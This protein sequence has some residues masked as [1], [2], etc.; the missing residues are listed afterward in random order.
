MINATR[1]PN[2]IHDPDGYI[3]NRGGKLLRV[4]SK[5]YYIN[6]LKLVGTGLH[7]RLLHN[8]LLLEHTSSPIIE[9]LT[10][11]PEVVP[12]ISYPYE[13]SFSQLR[14]AAL[15]TLTIQ[16]IA[17]EYGMTL[18]DAPASNIQFVDG[19]PMLI[20]ITSFEIYKEGKPW[21]AY[22]QFCEQFLAPLALA[23]YVSI[24]ALGWLKAYPD[25]VSLKLASKLIPKR[26]FISEL[27]LHL[28][29]HSRFSS[30]ALPKK[31]YM[32][33]KRLVSIV[34]SLY[35]TVARL[36]EPRDLTLWSNYYEGSSNYNKEAITAKEKAINEAL[37]IVMPDKVLD[38]GCNE[39]FYTAKIAR[40][41]KQVLAL[42]ND[43]QAIEFLYRLG[44]NNI[45]L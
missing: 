3:T 17:L 9:T 16:R 4:M 8:G 7:R 22:R 36:P 14:D 20:D 37:S 30:K 12:F 39:G 10:L 2:S 15:L 21:Q 32:S 41:V 11:E 18:K 28:Y 25:G 29:L 35:R 6:Y 31:P 38:L 1:I 43:Y 19:K 23:S 34:D 44:I 5:S 13:W 42:D 45:L 24:E 33:K 27:G 40:E 26:H